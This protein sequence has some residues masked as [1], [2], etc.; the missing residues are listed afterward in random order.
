MSE[1]TQESN[2][3]PKAQESQAVRRQ[4]EKNL[5][6]WFVGSIDQGTTSTRFL[7][8]N[9]HGNPVAS[10]QIEFKQFYPHSGYES[11]KASHPVSNG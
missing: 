8:F 11:F 10:H 5:N 7:L 4:D 6:D 9:G 3:E 2:A 1:P